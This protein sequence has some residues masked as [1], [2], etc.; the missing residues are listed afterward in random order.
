MKIWLRYIRG[1]W[2]SG[3][4]LNKHSINSVFLGYDE[5]GYRRFN[6]THT[7]VGEA[8][9]QLKYKNDWTQ[10]K[11]LAQAI[12]EHIYPKFANVGFIVPMP[13]SESRPSQPVTEIAK[14]LGVLVNVPVFDNVLS[15]K[16]SGTSLKN[17][18]TKDEKMK[19]IADSFSVHD[20]ISNDGQWNVLLVDD[21]FDTGATMEAATKA[22]RSYSKVGKIYVAALTWR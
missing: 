8:L 10:C 15:K 2:D 18:Q 5:Y 11:P 13:A 7:E 21:L 14:E 1:P 12:A 3:W 19:T 17:L 6:T 16:T 22:L 20:G 4:V 9:Y